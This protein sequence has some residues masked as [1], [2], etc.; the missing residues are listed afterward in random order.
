MPVKIRK[1]TN[2]E[3]EHFRQFSIEQNVSELVKKRNISFESAFEQTIA[4]VSAV[5]PDGLDSNDNLLMSIIDEE[6]N[7]NVGFIWTLHEETDGRKQSFICDFAIWESMRKKGYATAALHLT[8]KKALASGCLESV[9]FVSDDN[10]AAYKL[11]EKSGYKVLRQVNHGKY[12]I[13][14]LP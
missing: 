7:S 5:L 2:E 12:M 11:Y 14:Q 8:E 10:N 3:F 4:E 13:K 9:L 6:N 1:M